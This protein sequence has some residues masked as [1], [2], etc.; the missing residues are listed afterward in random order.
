MKKFLIF[1]MI[2]GFLIS[3]CSIGSINLSKEN[4]EANIN[5]Y[6]YI[7]NKYEDN[8]ECAIG[9]GNSYEAAVKDAKL[10]I[11]QNA[12]TIVKSYFEKTIQEK[13]NLAKKDIS[14]VKEFSSVNFSYLELKGINVVKKIKNGDCYFSV[15]VISKDNINKAIKDF[16]KK[17][18]AIMYVNLIQKTND[19]NLKLKYL[20]ELVDIVDIKKLYNDTVVVAG[21]VT[22]FKAYIDLMLN[23]IAKKVVPIFTGDKVY[24]VTKKNYFPLTGLKITLQDTN[25]KK[26]VFITDENGKVLVPKN[27]ELPINVYLNIGKKKF[28][29]GTLMTN[30]ISRIYLS[31]KPLG[32]NYE[33]MK[34]GKV[35][36]SG[37]TPNMIEVDGYGDYKIVLLP[38]KNYR[39]VEQLINVKKGYDAYFFRKMEKLRFGKVDLKAD[40]DALLFMKSI[41]GR[42]IAQGVKKIKGKIPVG[43]YKVLVKREDDSIDYQ[44]VYDNL[45]V[46]ENQKIKREYFEPKNREFYRTGWGGFLALSKQTPESVKINGNKYEGDKSKYDQDI[47]YIGGRKY[48]T[49]LFMGGG[50]GLAFYDDDND[51]TDDSSG[52]LYFD[53]ILGIYFP[54]SSGDV[55]F[56]AGYEYFNSS[57][58]YYDYKA[59][60]NFSEPF[61]SLKLNLLNGL[62]GLE[63]R[64]F[65]KQNVQ[66]T[67]S[68]GALFFNSDYEL[69]RE[70]EA[71][72][73]KDYE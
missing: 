21:S 73:G 28:L 55:E 22:T 15:V 36:S 20:S 52:G 27:F 62:I 4:C 60:A 42:N 40:G 23:K 33:I 1:T 54:F 9:A 38:S 35:I 26:G 32:L 69:K 44:K 17:A 11:T 63:L 65:K 53:S 67:I 66:F 5:K 64:G 24:I 3:G 37:S 56:G 57:K 47:L 12:L 61:G 70:K 39:E 31:T 6:N 58:D 7:C 71:I 16:M 45:V 59:T 41:D 68:F 2:F 50:I 25:G 34:Y 19:I 43:T 14:Q 29:I 18:D 10:K 30:N 46:S 49:H 72:R 13:D 51:N 48:W 8:Y